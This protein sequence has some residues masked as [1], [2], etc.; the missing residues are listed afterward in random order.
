MIEPNK[1]WVSEGQKI[2]NISNIADVIVFDWKGTQSDDYI[3]MSDAFYNAA[4]II[5]QEILDNFR[6]N[7]KCDQWFFPAIYLYRQ[8]IELLCKGLLI[9]VVPRKEITQ[10]LT[11]YKHNIIE[12]F[13]EYYTLIKN[14]KLTSKELLWVKSYLEDL[15]VI[16]KESNLFRYPIKDGILIQY[17][18]DFLNIVDM[19]NSIEQCFSIIY[20]CVDDKHHPLKY[21]DEIDLTME[22]KVLF[23]ASHGFGNCMLYTSPW[24][25]GYYNHIK[26]YSDIAYF[27]LN[28]LDKNHWSFLSIA[29]LVRH[30]VELALKCMLH[31]RTEFNVDEK[32][33]HRKQRSHI[34]YKDLWGSVKNMV[35]HYAGDM[36]NDINIIN[37]ADEYLRELSLLDKQGDKFRYPTNYGLEYHLA[38]EKIDYYQAIYW[39]ISIFNF[40]DGCASMLD[41]AYEYESDIRSEYVY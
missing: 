7:S 30:S 2:E 4:H 23:F 10:K 28:K 33:Q 25:D 39:M 6:D 37:Y 29:F 22:P 16:D 35:E 34:I 38:L 36:G 17:K 21:S 15:E 11:T 31:S 9:S 19:A 40:V 20:K 1:Y 13:D 12:L 18:N 27:L 32:I 26:G 8:A 3:I 24:D 14:D 41:A 5:V